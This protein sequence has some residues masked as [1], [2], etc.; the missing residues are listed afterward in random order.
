[1]P[2]NIILVDNRDTSIGTADKMAVH[3][4]GQ[5]HRAFSVF[6][7]N[8]TSE[9]LLQKRALTK[10]HSAGLWTNT[11]CSH[12]RPGETTLAAA[13]RRLQEEMGFTCQLTEAFSFTYQIAFTNEL[14]EHEYDHVFIGTFS[15]T[16]CPNPA[17]AAAWKWVTPA[18]L[19]TDL[20]RRPEHY[21]AW[22]KVCLDRVL[23]HPL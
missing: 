18:W 21:T 17:E 16:P 14:T 19:K 7:F 10:Y 2:K 20:K 4:N 1:M 11:C 15:G 12:P 5:L 3:K 13:R 22:L 6:I 8:D 23:A 9:M